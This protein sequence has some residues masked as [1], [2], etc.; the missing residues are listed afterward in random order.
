MP[1]PP[2]GVPGSLPSGDVALSGDTVVPMPTWANAGLQQMEVATAITS[3]GLMRT[4]QTVRSISK[5]IDRQRRNRLVRRVKSAAYRTRLSSS[6]MGLR[7]RT[8]TKYGFRI[9]TSPEDDLDFPYRTTQI[10][11]R[12]WPRPLVG[13]GRRAIPKFQVPAHLRVIRLGTKIG[14]PERL[15]WIPETLPG[16]SAVVGLVA[17]SAVVVAG[18]VGIVGTGADAAG[19][20]KGEG[21]GVGTVAKELTPR[22]A[23]SQAPSGMPAL[24]LPP[25]V[26]GV[27]DVGADGDI[28]GPL[29]PAPHIPDTPIIPIAEL[30]DI[31]AAGNVPGSVG[32][33]DGAEISAVCALPE[34]TVM[35]VIADTVAVAVAGV[36]VDPMIIP[37]PS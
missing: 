37:P 20:K 32:G 27:V 24:G 18:I 11:N 22:L 25:G 19:L 6:Q 36:A 31:P 8:S 14:I 1:V 35:S 7:T 16:G 12:A 9:L 3:N 34:F 2:A 29:D 28:G 17:G 15:V 4:P 13:G 30:V 26:A 33:A 5:T 23:I 10:A 21:A